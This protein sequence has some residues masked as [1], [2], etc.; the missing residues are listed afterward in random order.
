MA[1]R[2]RQKRGSQL[3]I[4]FFYVLKDFVK[5]VIGTLLL[6][7]FLFLLFDFIHKTTRYIP[8]YNPDTN[9]LIKYYIYFIP[10]LIAQ[11]LPI[12]SLL[13][14]VVTMVLLSRRLTEKYPGPWPKLRG[15]VLSPA[16]FV[17]NAP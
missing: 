12:A 1:L 11:A 3:M 2:R 15:M 16:G 17:S 6:V 10:N 5:Y 7:V 8:R 14:S 4:L 13:A 9:L